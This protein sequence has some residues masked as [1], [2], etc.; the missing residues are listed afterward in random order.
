MKIDLVEAELFHVDR[1]TDTMKLIVAFPNFQM[2]QRN[3]KLS[4]R[5]S[6]LMDDIQ[7]GEQSKLYAECI[8]DR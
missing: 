4:H 7:I 6:L 2:H 8:N 3:V 5:F 1:W